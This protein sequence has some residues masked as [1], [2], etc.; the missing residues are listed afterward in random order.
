MNQYPQSKLACATWKR[1]K[2]SISQGN[3]QTKIPTVTARELGEGAQKADNTKL[4]R[5]N[6]VRSLKTSE[7][8]Q[9]GNNSAFIFLNGLAI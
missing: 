7:V 8:W 5:K 4:L 9:Q 6:K 2:Y 3:V 1:I